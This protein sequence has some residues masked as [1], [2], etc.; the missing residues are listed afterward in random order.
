MPYTAKEVLREPLHA[1]FIDGL[2]TGSHKI[3]HHPVGR[4]TYV[5]MH[6]NDTPT[7]TFRKILKQAQ[8]S[9]EEFKNL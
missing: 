9:E 2:Q 1:R 5:S 4:Q 3:L 8:H 6:T 7:G